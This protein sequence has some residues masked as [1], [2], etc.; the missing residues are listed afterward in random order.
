MKIYRLFY[1][2]VVLNL[3]RQLYFRLLAVTVER[4][5]GFAVNLTLPFSANVK[6]YFRPVCSLA[7][8]IVTGYYFVYFTVVCCPLISTF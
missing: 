1:D 3:A 8:L 6:T 5:V 2:K 4:K 7:T